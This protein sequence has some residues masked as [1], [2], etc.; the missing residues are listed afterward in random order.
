MKKLFSILCCI[1]L[2]V[3]AAACGEAPGSAEQSTENPIDDN[4]TTATEPQQPY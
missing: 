4:T 1:A 2:L 3:C